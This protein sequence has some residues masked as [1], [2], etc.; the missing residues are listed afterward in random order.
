MGWEGKRDGEW[1][2]V[3]AT[4]RVKFRRHFVADK[5]S[6]PSDWHMGAATPNDTRAP[7]AGQI[8]LVELAPN[9]YA[10]VRVVISP[11]ITSPSASN[12]T[13]TTDYVRVYK[14]TNVV[15]Y[16]IPLQSTAAN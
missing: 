13:I 4:N 7:S 16:F 11:H 10:P 12:S 2:A 14:T 1:R 3:C 9:A 15:L 6:D 5:K 8:D